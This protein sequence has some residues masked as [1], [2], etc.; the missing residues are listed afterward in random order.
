VKNK[1]KPQTQQQQQQQK[2]ATHSLSS[3]KTGERIG[4]VK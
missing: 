3:D 1:T 2:A 4:K